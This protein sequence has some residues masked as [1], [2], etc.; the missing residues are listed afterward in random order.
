MITFLIGGSSVFFAEETNHMHLISR[1]SFFK[2]WCAQSYANSKYSAEKQIHKLCRSVEPRMFCSCPGC[3]APPPFGIPR[4]RGKPEKPAVM[5]DEPI[6][7]AQIG[8]L[9]KHMTKS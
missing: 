6:E 8:D 5:S 7:L 3:V 4:P 2:I 9:D 1:L